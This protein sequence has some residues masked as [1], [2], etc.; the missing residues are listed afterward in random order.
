MAK[1]LFN[2]RPV[3]GIAAIVLCAGSVSAQSLVPQRGFKGLFGGGSTD[4]RHSLTFAAS[5][6]E[7]YDSDT[8][9]DVL[10]VLGRTSPVA[11]G[12]SSLLFAAGNYGWRSRR[13]QFGANAASAWRYYNEL[14]D[15]RTV[16]HS[17]V[18][19]VVANLPL[20]ITL[21]ANQTAS[22]TPSYLYRLFPSAAVPIGDDSPTAAPP[23]YSVLQYDVR[24]Y[25]SLMTVARGFGWRT[26]VSLTGQYQSNSFD[27]GLPGRG[28]AT[29][30]FRAGFSH[31]LSRYVTFVSQ[32]R[33][34]ARDL[35]N[36]A[37]ADTNEHG[38]NAGVDYSLALSAS[39][40]A[41]L[42]FRAG[43]ASVTRLQTLMINDVLAD[44]YRLL[45]A[46]VSLAYPFGRTWQAR[47]TYRRGFE[48][49]AGFQ[50]PVYTNGVIAY[51]D[52]SLSRRLDLMASSGF[53]TGESVLNRDSLYYDTYTATAQLR[54]ALGRN[55]A[56]SVQY[57]LYYY[58]FRGITDPN[59]P[60]PP[61][62][63]RNGLRAGLTMWFPIMRRQ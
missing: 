24:S 31:R 40:R 57:L 48:Y 23:D 35:R 29:R 2:L 53:S 47:A 42:G 55:L 56:A 36:S 6:S 60:L 41:V 9:R 5:L 19:G 27:G 33:Y 61:G 32:Y 15:I 37:Q 45:S 58:D 63:T 8:A 28:D 20:R 12:Y 59:S 46:Q 50:D 17:G 52:G 49:L 16:S 51:L 7:L 13:V 30:G 38:I 34:R 44:K 3:V 26:S 39:R 14:R 1:R 62:L 10:P 22:L 25:H 21:T 54:Y 4:V 11:G 18:L 43:V